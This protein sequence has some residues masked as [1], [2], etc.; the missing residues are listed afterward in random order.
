LS[1]A[2]SVAGSATNDSLSLALESAFL[3]YKNLHV[4]KVKGHRIGPEELVPDHA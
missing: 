1:A 2:A 4:L 3:L